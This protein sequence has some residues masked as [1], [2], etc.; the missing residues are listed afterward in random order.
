MNVVYKI[1]ALYCY[2]LPH[3]VRFRGQMNDFIISTKV[4]IIIMTMMI[5]TLIIILTEFSAHFCSSH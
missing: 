1:N 2:H 4:M 3:T 5:I